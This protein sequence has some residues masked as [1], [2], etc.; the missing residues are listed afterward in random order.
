MTYYTL[1]VIFIL[2][3]KFIFSIFLVI[4]LKR[5]DTN[6]SKNNEKI[7][8]DWLTLTLTMKKG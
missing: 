1:L 4:E 8:S 7:E 2:V 3:Q 6:L 5:G